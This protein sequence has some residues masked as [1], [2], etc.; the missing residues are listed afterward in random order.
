[1]KRVIHFGFIIVLLM[2]HH[3]LYAQTYPSK[4][5]SVVD[6]DTIKILHGK[7]QEKIR[8]IYID[9]PEM[10]QAYGKKAKQA[11][12]DY[13]YGKEVSL[14]RYEQDHYGRT[15]AE[16]FVAERNI[17]VALVREGHAWA[18]RRYTDSPVYLNAEKHARIH[19]LGLWRL[20]SDQQ[21]APWVWR[22]NERSRR[23]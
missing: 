10:S 20:P 21:T 9:A 15:L 22:K 3:V 12:A 11:L 19:K 8:L 7:K 5:I 4:V 23:K 16:V 14:K 2:M 6:G 13:L 17:N 1:M 18:Y